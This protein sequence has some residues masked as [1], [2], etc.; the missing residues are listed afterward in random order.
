MLAYT[1]LQLAYFDTLVSLNI[2]AVSLNITFVSLNSTLVSLHLN[3]IFVSL[4]LHRNTKLA[5]AVDVMMARAKRL[6]ILMIKVDKLFS[7]F[8]RGVLKRNDKHVLHVSIEFYYNSKSI[9]MQI[10]LS[11]WLRYSY[12]ISHYSSPLNFLRF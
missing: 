4:K 10:L 1:A 9:L 3:I 11:D 7:C 6:R 8:R 2:T 12:T 5:E